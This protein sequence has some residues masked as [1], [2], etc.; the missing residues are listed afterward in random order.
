MCITGKDEYYKVMPTTYHEDVAK[1]ARSPNM[2][3]KKCQIKFSRGTLIS[4]E[5]TS[6]PTLT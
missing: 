6:F 1:S 4:R 3:P 5:H 2:K